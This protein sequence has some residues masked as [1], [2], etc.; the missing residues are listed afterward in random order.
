MFNLPDLEEGLRRSNSHEIWPT[1]IAS[2]D[3]YGLHISDCDW[4]REAH[5]R[6]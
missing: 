3:G 5:E 1:G 2:V 4:K 6:G